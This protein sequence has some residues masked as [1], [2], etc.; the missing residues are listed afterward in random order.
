VL[1]ATNKETNNEESNTV[2][3]SPLST[4]VHRLDAK[5]HI[6]LWA[7]IWEAW[8]GGMVLSIN[9]GKG[10]CIDGTRVA[11]PR[12][13]L[14][15]L[16]QTSAALHNHLCPRQV[17]GVRM[18]IYAGELL[19]LQVPQAD[20]RL[21]VIVETDGCFADGV[22]AAT[23]CW[24]GRRTM[25]VEDY[26]KAAATFVDTETGVALRLA[27]RREARQLAEEYA[28]DAANHWEAML[29][30][31]QR[32]ESPTLFHVQPVTLRTPLA[33]IISGCAP[34]MPPLRRRDHQRA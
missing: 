3:S 2:Q 32:I 27:P 18:G 21:L 33:Q 24:I 4:R 12:K 23:N 7:S 17:L 1:S 28:P 14:Q 30:G 29:L 11:E 22:A 5:L 31:Y 25:R 26:G 8:L 6:V 20:K 16:L 19:A 15:E 13:F 9:S 34:H 10:G